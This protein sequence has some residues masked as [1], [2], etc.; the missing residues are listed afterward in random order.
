MNKIMRS[1]KR[2]RWDKPVELRWPS[3][4]V[5]DAYILQVREG[6][7][8]KAGSGNKGLGKAPGS[9]FHIVE[10]ESLTLSEMMGKSNY[11]AV[12][13]GMK[14]QLLRLIN[15]CLELGFIHMNELVPTGT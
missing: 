13:R 11:E 2:K 4:S 10:S 3:F 5:K 14:Q 8:K 9:G 12:L 1:E 15:D 7:G 6:G